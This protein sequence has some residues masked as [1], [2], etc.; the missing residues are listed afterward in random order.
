MKNKRKNYIKRENILLKI[1]VHLFLFFF[2]VCSADEV[3]GVIVSLSVSRHSASLSITALVCVPA[4][5]FYATVTHCS[6]RQKRRN[7]GKTVT[8]CRKHRAAS[9]E[10]CS[11]IMKL[12]RKKKG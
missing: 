8:P 6:S 1:I 12:S 11:R 4:S 3:P 9:A 10:L 2:S 7:D 5:C